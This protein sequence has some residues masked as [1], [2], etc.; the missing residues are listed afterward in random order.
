M[1]ILKLREDLNINKFLN[2]NIYG[3][4]FRGSYIGYII[5]NFIVEREVEVSNAW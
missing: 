3:V 2:L 1:I 5:D 4:S